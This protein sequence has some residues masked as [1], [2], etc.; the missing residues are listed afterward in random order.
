MKV[1]EM[2]RDK[3]IGPFHEDVLAPSLYP[4]VFSEELYQSRPAL[5]PNCFHLETQGGK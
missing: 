2:R 5:T 4:W 3:E 1:N